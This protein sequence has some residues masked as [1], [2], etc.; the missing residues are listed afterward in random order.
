MANLKQIAARVGVS[1][2]TVS[3]AINGN[4][5]ISKATRDKVLTVMKE[6]NYVPNEVARS[7][8][9]RSNSH[10]IGLI[11]PYINHSF[12]STLT[13]AIEESCYKAG[14]RLFLCTSAGKIER[15]RELLDM[16]RA[17]NV[18][19]ILVCSRVDD[20]TDYIACGVPLVSIERNFD[21]VPSVSCDNYQGGV[22]AANELYEQGVRHP[23]M[24]GNQHDSSSYLPA[25]LRYQG[26]THACK[27]LGAPCQEIY[28]EKEDL[29]GRGIA[30]AL[31]GTLEKNPL[32]DGIFT[33]SD[34]LAVRVSH[35]LSSSDKKTRP[36]IGFDGLDLTEY[37]DITTVAQ[38]ITQ[39][40]QMAVDVLIRRING[41]LIPER[42]ILPVKLI[43]RKS[44][45]T[46]C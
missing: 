10:I 7:L 14:Y 31:L 44:T 32:I 29:F 5:S 16:F 15:E 8:T 6:M 22:L 43:P 36:I 11:V 33:T 4:K 38:P 3:R 45:R 1:E 9:S 13:A 35:I 19:G 39:M 2:A 30:D 40:G 46:T 42:S 20:G 17:S 41:L 26:F 21:H 27:Q 37:N 12:F 28:L 23:L 24:I 25:N 18:A 34:V